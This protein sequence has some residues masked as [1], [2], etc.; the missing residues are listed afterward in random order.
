M[1]SCGW[2]GD[3]VLSPKVSSSPH[4][5]VPAPGPPSEQLQPFGLL[6]QTKQGPSGLA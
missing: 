4:P 2:A 3:Q 1:K 5:F 6:H